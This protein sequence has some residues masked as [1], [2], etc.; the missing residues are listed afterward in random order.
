MIYCYQCL[1]CGERCSKNLPMRDA[2]M[3]PLCPGCSATMERDFIA[4]HAGKDSV[5]SGCDNWREFTPDAL[6]VH[7]SQ[8][9]EADAWAQKHGLNVRH[10][11]D[12]GRPIFTGRKQ[13]KRYAELQGFHARNGGY[14]DPQKR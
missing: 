14:G 8:A 5:R 2:Q 1:Q 7:P 12:D 6:A 3:R 4:E 9:A 11:R 13:Y 10:R